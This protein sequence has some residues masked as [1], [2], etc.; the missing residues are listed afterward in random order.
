MMKFAKLP[1]YGP[2]ARLRARGRD[3]SRPIAIKLSFVNKTSRKLLRHAESS[4][5]LTAQELPMETVAQVSA[6]LTT[7]L[8]TAAESAAWAT[9]LVR[10][11]SPLTGPRFVQ[12]LVLGWLRQP[13]ATWSDLACTAAQVGAPVSPQA[14][15]Q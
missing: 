3:S 15:Y 13:A 6:A 14:L 7:V 5:P 9:G 4:H 12:A 1:R 2:G 10:R 8:T 11:P